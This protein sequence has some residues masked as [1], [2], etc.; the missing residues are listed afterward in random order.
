MT[1]NYSR[2]RGKLYDTMTD[3]LISTVSYTINEDLGRDGKTRKWWGELTFIESVRIAEG[4]RYRLQLA[5]N[6]RGQCALR[7]RTNKAVISV[8]S[9]FFYMLQGTGPL[10]DSPAVPGE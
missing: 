5:D 9:R 1:T 8:P 7:R 4:N 3:E 6:R 10:T 2:G